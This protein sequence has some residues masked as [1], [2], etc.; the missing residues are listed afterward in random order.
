MVVAETVEVIT[1][2]G[3]LGGLRSRKREEGPPL[4]S[5][6]CPKSRADIGNSVTVDVSES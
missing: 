4:F 2:S 5:A 3:C 6:S 1:A